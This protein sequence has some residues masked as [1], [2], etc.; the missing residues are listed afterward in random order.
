MKPGMFTAWKIISGLAL[1]VVA[2]AVLIVGS[3]DAR[4]D[5][6]LRA[7]GGSFEGSIVGGVIGGKTSTDVG[8][9]VDGLSG[10]V[11]GAGQRHSR[12]RRY[13]RSRMQL[14]QRNKQ[15]RDVSGTRWQ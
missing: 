12:Y 7:I 10:S 3:A 8:A 13:N 6:F 2:G 5:P 1:P 15:R 14:P 4:A 9:K 11:A